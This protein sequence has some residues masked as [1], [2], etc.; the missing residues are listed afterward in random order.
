MRDL[1]NK[2]I[3]LES[4]D[5]TKIANESGLDI[6]KIAEGLTYKSG[7]IAFFHLAW[8]DFKM[9]TI[10]SN[11]KVSQGVLV[12]DNPPLW[13]TFDVGSTNNPRKMFVQSLISAGLGKD[14]AMNLP[15]GAPSHNDIF[16]ETRYEVTPT[17]DYVKAIN[18]AYKWRQI[19]IGDL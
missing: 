7:K 19:N 2:L 18:A 4:S 13:F 3:L 5:G 14:I 10:F 12:T 9:Y 16:G 1:I 15:L 11:F 17:A 6:V 8:F